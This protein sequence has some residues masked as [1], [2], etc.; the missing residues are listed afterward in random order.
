MTEPAPRPPFRSVALPTGDL[1][2]YQ[3]LAKG[4]VMVTD[5]TGE[6][7]TVLGS[8][9]LVVAGNGRRVVR[10][11]R[12]TD[13]WLLSGWDWPAAQLAIAIAT[14]S[15]P[16]KGTAVTASTFTTTP[17]P[18][19]RHRSADQTARALPD[20][21]AHAAKHA[22]DV[23]VKCSDCGWRAVHIAALWEHVAR[24]HPEAVAG[25]PFAQRP[26]I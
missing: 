14:R 19:G 15:T 4:D 20:N 9:Y 6:Q 16:R 23:D 17:G 7:P 22:T 5:T 13:S 1:V 11:S 3:V 8:A 25:S 21:P 10:L 26:R 18:V 24:A 12:G 2:T